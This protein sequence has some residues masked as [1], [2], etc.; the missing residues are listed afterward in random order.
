MT[1]CVSK[2]FSFFPFNGEQSSLTSLKQD[3][4]KKIVIDYTDMH[5]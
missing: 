2:T 3:I 4:E 1:R 5:H